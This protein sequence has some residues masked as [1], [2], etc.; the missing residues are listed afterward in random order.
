MDAGM[1]HASLS[2]RVGDAKPQSFADL[3]TFVGQ[4]LTWVTDHLGTLITPENKVVVID[5]V[6][7]FYDQVTAGDTL[8][9]VPDFI[10]TPMELAVRRGLEQLLKNMLG[11]E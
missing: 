2:E 7:K 4:L 5:A 9:R 10:E 8:P 11:V 6:L 3:A 1:M